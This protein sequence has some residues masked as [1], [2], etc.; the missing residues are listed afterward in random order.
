MLEQRCGHKGLGGG[1]L[2]GIEEIRDASG[3]GKG[4]AEVEK[5]ISDDEL[6]DGGVARVEGSQGEESDC[7]EEDSGD[8]HYQSVFR[9]VDAVVS[10]RHEFD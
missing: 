8:H 1:V 9:F 3:R 5:E 6:G 10:A 7:A 2:H 4:T